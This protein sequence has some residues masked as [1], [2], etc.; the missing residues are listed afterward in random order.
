MYRHMMSWN[1]P[2]DI[3]HVPAC[4]TNVKWRSARVPSPS[5]V[6]FPWRIAHRPDMSLSPALASLKAAD[7]CDEAKRGLPSRT[8]VGRHPHIAWPSV[9]AELDICLYKDM[10]ILC[11]AAVTAVSSFAPPPPWGPFRLT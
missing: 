5:L 3:V 6:L 9:I 2:G 1:I 7:A 10:R 11:A 4:R 8:K